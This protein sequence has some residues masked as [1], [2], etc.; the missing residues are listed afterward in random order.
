[1]PPEVP[2]KKSPLQITFVRW[3][4]V[5]HGPFFCM[6][7]Y[8]AVVIQ[9]GTRP[10][11]RQ[12]RIWLLRRASAAAAVPLEQPRP[13]G[14]ITRCSPPPPSAISCTIRSYL[15]SA[16]INIPSA[17]RDVILHR[18]CDMSGPTFDPMHMRS[19]TPLGRASR[20]RWFECCCALFARHDCAN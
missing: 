2:R 6:I 18:S 12:A 13:A 15:C 7:L 10:A 20:A 8:Y 16:G 19:V 14:A 3:Q 17:L 5:S 9:N 11:D 1:M 4:R